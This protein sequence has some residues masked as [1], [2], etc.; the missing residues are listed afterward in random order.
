MPSRFLP[1]SLTGFVFQARLHLSIP[2]P[3]SLKTFHS[4]E[5]AWLPARFVDLSG[6]YLYTN[7]TNS[8]KIDN[9]S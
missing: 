1:V 3:E 4:V 7:Y 5:E 8:K 9:G 2:V 6:S